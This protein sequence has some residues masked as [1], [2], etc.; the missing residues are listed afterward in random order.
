[1]ATQRGD[2]V[3]RHGALLGL[4]ELKCN[5]G[6]NGVRSFARDFRKIAMALNDKGFYDGKTRDK[7][8]VASCRKLHTRTQSKPEIGMKDRNNRT[9]LLERQY[10][11]MIT[12]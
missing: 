10:L 5:T 9:A 4:S 1:M 7:M 8:R 2:V 6:Q 3:L 11:P 12:T